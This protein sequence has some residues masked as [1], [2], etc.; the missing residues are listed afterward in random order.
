MHLHRPHKPPRYAAAMRRFASLDGTRTASTPRRGSAP[1][2]RHPG[3][4]GRVHTHGLAIRLAAV[5]TIACEGTPA[6]SHHGARGAPF[7]DWP[8]PLR[9]ES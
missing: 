4:R 7:P 9:C 5:G 1:S 3:E 2:S 8:A 6:W